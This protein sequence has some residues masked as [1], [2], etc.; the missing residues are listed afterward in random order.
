VGVKG[1]NFLLPQLVSACK[2]YQWSR[3]LPMLCY[4]RCRYRY[5]DD[6][7]PSS[8]SSICW[9]QSELLTPLVD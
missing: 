5:F 3:C 7:W 8:I 6:L 2:W 4:F 1:L 9:Q